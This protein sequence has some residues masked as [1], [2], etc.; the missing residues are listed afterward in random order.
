MAFFMML[1][2]INKIVKNIYILKF[3]ISQII[4]L[5]GKKQSHL[6]NIIISK[7]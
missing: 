4:I 2:L 1:R 6:K 5:I 7:E 3:Y